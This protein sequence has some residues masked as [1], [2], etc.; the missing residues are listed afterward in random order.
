MRPVISLTTDFGLKD[1]FVGTMKGVIAE[2]CPE[3]NIIDITHEIPA[4]DVLEGALAIWPAWRYFPAGTVHVVV[5]DPGVGTERRPILARL[6]GHY[7]IAPDNG[8]LTLMLEDIERTGPPPVLHELTTP[9]YKLGTQSLTFH[10]RDIFAPAAAHLAKQLREDS[11]DLNAFGPRIEKPLL[12]KTNRPTRGPDGAVSG[13]ILKI[14]R[15]GN[16]LTNLQSSDAA[17]LRDRHF[18]L[19]LKGH[20]ITR[21]LR[22]YMAGEPGEPFVILGSSGLLEIALNR[23]SAAKH[24]GSSPGDP[25]TLTVE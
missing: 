12:L 2:I 7:F 15:F 22:N 20:K 11:V 24:L 17:Q 13:T 19:D 6:G 8:L 9:A 14:D 3:A 5:V 10:G 18:A 21:S 25:F 16:L 23:G 1:H 4:F